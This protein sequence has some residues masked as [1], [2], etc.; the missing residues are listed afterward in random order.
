MKYS[1]KKKSKF[2]V[3]VFR[4]L[5]KHIL[6]YLSWPQEDPVQTKQQWTV[7]YRSKKKMMMHET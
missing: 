5:L 4:F 7:N 1:I 2:S 3:L 6:S